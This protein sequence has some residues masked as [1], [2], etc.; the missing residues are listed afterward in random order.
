MKNNEEKWIEDF[1]NKTAGKK[2]IKGLKKLEDGRNS[3][4]IKKFI[5]SILHECYMSREYDRQRDAFELL[6]KINIK[7]IRKISK[8]KED[9]EN[10]LQLLKDEKTLSSAIARFFIQLLQQKGIKLIFDDTNVDNE[11]LQI[12][13][14]E[15]ETRVLHAQLDQLNELVLETYLE[16]LEKI[17]EPEFMSSMEANRVR[18]N[19]DYSQS[20]INRNQR[21]HVAIIGL[22]YGLTLI[23]ENWLHPRRIE[24]KAESRINIVQRGDQLFRQRSSV[25]TCLKFHYYQLVA[26]FVNATHNTNFA[27]EDIKDKLAKH[28]QNNPKITYVPPLILDS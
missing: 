28:I 15:D 16:S 20:L 11:R 24:K 7:K 2:A 13:S 4:D 10:L 25:N 6:R 27:S 14:T 18:G 26:D 5:N 17:T 12:V 21:P 9:I 3:E 1:K 8:G 19:M 23:I 22:I